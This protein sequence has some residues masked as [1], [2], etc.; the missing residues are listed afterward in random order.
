MDRNKFFVFLCLFFKNRSLG[1]GLVEFALTLPV[2]LYI[3]IGVVDL[4]RGIIANTII[5]NAAREGARAAIYPSPTGTTQT[6]AN[7][8][9][10]D[11]VK[12]E[13]AFL[14]TIPDSPTGADPG[15]GNYVVIAAN[16]WDPV[17]KTYTMH[18][19]STSPPAERTSSSQ[20]I[21]TVHYRFL[22]ITPILD[23]LVGNSINLTA[24]S[25]MMIE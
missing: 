24:K 9:V 3:T 2:F 15:A 13:S 7:A 19:P 12:T 25:T 22:P 20:I 16:T 17:N 11:A 8:V 10:V 4:G 5:S 21:V 23:R 14:G 6:A 1:Q 18:N